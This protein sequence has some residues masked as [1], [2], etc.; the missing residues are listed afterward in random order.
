MKD[1]IKNSQCLFDD[2][3]LLAA[4]ERL[5]LK[6][7]QKYSMSELNECS[8]CKKKLSKSSSVNI[9]CKLGSIYDLLTELKNTIET[10]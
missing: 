3:E 8:V 4:I 2:K 9:H 7:D 1:T 5:Y 6:L 10:L